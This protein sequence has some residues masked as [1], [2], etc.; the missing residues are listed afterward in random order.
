[1][2]WALDTLWRRA[3]AGQAASRVAAGALLSVTLIAFTARTHARNGDWGD[4]QRFLL[5]A[6]VAAPDSYKTTM[7]AAAN[8]IISTPQDVARSIRY[9]D[10]SLAILDGLPDA[11][12]A[13]GAYR[14][15]G[16][17]YGILGDRVASAG[18]QGNAAVG[19]DALVWYRKS[20][21][22][23]LR[24]E[25]IDLA[26]DEQYRTENRVRGKPGLTS[27]PSK[28]YLELGRAY[29]RLSDRPHALEAFERGRTLESL[30]ELLEELASAYRA[31]GDLRKAALALVE[32]LAVDPSRIELA[33]KLVEIYG[34]IDPQGC[35]VT[36]QGGAASL[37][38]DCPLVHGD[39]CAA[40]RNVIGNYLRR[41]Q[42]FEADSI[43]RVAGQD[44]GCASALLN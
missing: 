3:P 13:P 44:L 41:G 17:L 40:S 25:K 30:P 36:R 43:R 8:T 18:A 7:T 32:A 29:L 37:N 24:S 35:S 16:I 1:V 34:Q 28:L 15:A 21:N 20:L 11:H 33:S 39:I 26:W 27:L 22:A 38:P 10:R 6:A 31:A 12:N 19:S 42:Q 23:L 4:P 5:S 14:D 9:A 2:V